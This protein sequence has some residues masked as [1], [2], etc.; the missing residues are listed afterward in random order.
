MMAKSI[1]QK[2]WHVTRATSFT[3]S[4]LALLAATPALAAGFSLM[5]VSSGGEPALT[6]GVWYPCATPPGKILIGTVTVLGAIDCPVAG[7]HLPLVAIS[8]G[9]GSSFVGH[10]DVAEALA[11]AGFIV[12]AINHPSDSGR[13]PQRDH[14]DP[15]AALTD[16]PA[17][18]KRLIDFMLGA[19]PSAAKIN[20]DRIGLFGFSRGGFTGRDRRRKEFSR[21]SSSMVSR[22]LDAARLHRSPLHGIPTQPLV[23]DPHIKAAVIADPLL[24]RFF[25]PRG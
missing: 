8:H 18:I 20:R 9:F 1:I 19:R 24:G 22:C 21:C 11:D 3:L 5:E 23:H 10:H 12:A 13:S 7:D 25:R 4:C 17:D 16:R 14:K 6:G 15:L 2:T